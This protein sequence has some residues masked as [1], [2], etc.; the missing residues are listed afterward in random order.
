MSLG[1][2]LWMPHSRASESA[3]G[4]KKP[5]NSAGAK[6]DRKIPQ[7]REEIRNSDEVALR[8]ADESDSGEPLNPVYKNLP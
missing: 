4:I 3:L 8:S 6:K 7:P 5:F 1:S 2:F